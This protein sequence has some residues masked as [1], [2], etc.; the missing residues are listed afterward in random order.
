MLDVTTCIVVVNELVSKAKLCLV[1][2][3]QHSVEDY[4][5]MRNLPKIFLRSFENVGPVLLLIYI[6]YDVISIGWA[7]G[8]INGLFM[9][10]LYSPQSC[11][12]PPH[13]SMKG[14]LSADDVLLFVRLSVCRNIDAQLV[15][16]RGRRC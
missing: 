15:F 13:L 12:S 7:V 8:R 14:A 6:I 9:S 2:G 1:S 10:G 5:K 16:G 3:L 4:P 11:E